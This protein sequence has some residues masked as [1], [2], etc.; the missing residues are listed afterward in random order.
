M[1][2]A[3]NPTGIG[4]SPAGLEP[5]FQVFG[6]TG[7]NS[8]TNFPRRIPD[9]RFAGNRTGIG[10][11]PAFPDSEDIGRESGAGGPRRGPRAR[12]FLTTDLCGLTLSLP[13]QAVPSN[14]K[15]LRMFH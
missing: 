9:S 2:R 4:K 6:K 15:P 11:P 7:V 3:G 5:G 14:S 8:V 12:G 10:K 13:G 1:L